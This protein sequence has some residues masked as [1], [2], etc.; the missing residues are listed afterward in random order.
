MV[1]SHSHSHGHLENIITLA[2][3]SKVQLHRCSKT[4]SL[5]DLCLICCQAT[6]WNAARKHWEI[7]G[8]PR[9]QSLR[10]IVLF[11]VR[12]TSL[13]Q[14]PCLWRQILGTHRKANTW[15]VPV[16]LVLSA[17][18][19]WSL[20]RLHGFLW[21]PLEVTAWASE[22]LSCPIMVLFFHSSKDFQ[23]C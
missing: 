1:N 11:L 7:L 3:Y 12:T 13:H 20:F 4:L 18:F 19:M 16:S 21:V 5:V 8:P 6:S 23:I 17:I 2:C 14:S 10:H 9:I 15:D 22:S